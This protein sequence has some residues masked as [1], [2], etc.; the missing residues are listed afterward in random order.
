MDGWDC[1][2]DESSCGFIRCQSNM[3]G[4]LPKTRR[5]SREGSKLADDVCLA[6]VNLDSGQDFRLI[7]AAEVMQAR[8]RKLR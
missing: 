7:D 4:M 5:R 2:D 1:G 8:S 6:G 3:L